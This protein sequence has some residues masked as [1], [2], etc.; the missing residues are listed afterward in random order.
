M[1]IKA[2]YN[3]SKIE[4]VHAQRIDE[5]RDYCQDLSKDSSNGF[6][7]DKTMRRIGS[8]PVFTLMEYDR[9]HPGWYAQASG[10]KDPRERTRIWKQFLDSDY[11]RPFMT[12]ER[13][14]H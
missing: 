3:G 7:K 11:A 14:K 6:T 1:L 8:F 2:R 12:V 5:I 4:A 13:M 10:E 9:T